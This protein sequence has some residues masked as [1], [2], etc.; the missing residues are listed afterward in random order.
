MA[1]ADGAQMLDGALMPKWE[2][3]QAGP[4][5]AM[6]GGAG[7]GVGGISAV[8]AGKTPCG[9]QEAGSEAAATVAAAAA[10]AAEAISVCSQLKLLLMLSLLQRPSA[11]NH[12]Q[13]Q[14]RIETQFLRAA[15]LLL[16]PWETGMQGWKG[17][18]APLVRVA[19]HDTQQDS[20]F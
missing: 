20:W 15:H 10:A 2:G 12:Q 8:D 11:S 6:V 5:E 17:S 4:A 19:M 18:F 9:G 7:E 14:C 1:A 3:P 16:C 13:N